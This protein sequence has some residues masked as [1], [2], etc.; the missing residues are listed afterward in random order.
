MSPVTVP[1]W[2]ISDRQPQT[3]VCIK[4]FEEV[5]GELQRADIAV[6]YTVYTSSAECFFIVGDFQ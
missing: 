4:L 3:L 6:K 5:L 1:Q 2:H